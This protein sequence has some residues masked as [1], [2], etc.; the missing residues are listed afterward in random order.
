MAVDEMLLNTATAD[1][2]TLRFYEWSEPT[3]SLGYFQ[4]LAAREQHAASRDCPVV[5]RASGGGAIVHDRELT[6]SFVSP[7][8]NRFSTAAKRLYAAFHGTL[9]ETLAEF[10]IR[11]DLCQSRTTS[12][13]TGTA[14][15]FLCFERQTH[16]DVLSGGLKICGSAQ[17]RQRGAMLQH[18]SVLLARSPSAP[19]LPGI[20]DLAGMTISAGTLQAAWTVRLVATL[21]LSL[22]PADLS[23]TESRFQI[24]TIIDQ[25]FANRNWAARR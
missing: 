21:N 24:Q 17:R 18:G 11:A 19:E 12:P 10:G 20:R 5:R 14:E 15:P 13:E 3:L 23:D 25:Q 7:L 16:G 9:I 8:G 1:T 22:I 4:P 6:Y 2:A